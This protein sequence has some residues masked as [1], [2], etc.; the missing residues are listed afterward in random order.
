MEILEKAGV[1]GYN[2]F[3]RDDAKFINLKNEIYKQI[4]K[5]SK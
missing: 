5:Y 3:V 4:K 1:K 2:D